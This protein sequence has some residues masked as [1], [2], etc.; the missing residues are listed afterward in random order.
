MTI[1]TTNW[2]PSSRDLRWFA[3]LQTLVVMFVITRWLSG[4]S[5]QTLAW[6]LGLASAVVASLGLV[7]PAAIRPLYVAWMVI[8]FP[9]GLVMSWG[10]VAIVYYGILTPIALVLRVGG[11]DPLQS[12]NDSQ[13][14]SWWIDR[15]PPPPVDR[16][17]RQF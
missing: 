16:Y 8:V 3:V 1:L 4:P 17:F 13:R 12:R 6:G 2:H 15:P 7:S 11:H 10:L 14:E 9:L 5:E